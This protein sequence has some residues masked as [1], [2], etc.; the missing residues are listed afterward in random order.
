MCDNFEKIQDKR[1]K[2]KFYLMYV[3]NIASFSYI[4]SGMDDEKK[5]FWEN[6]QNNRHLAR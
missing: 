6:L 3:L 2:Y 4:I 5:I 1:D